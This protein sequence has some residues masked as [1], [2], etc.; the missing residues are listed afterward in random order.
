MLPAGVFTSDFLKEQV[1]FFSNLRQGWGSIANSQQSSAF[2]W[3]LTAAAD[4]RWSADGKTSDTNTL[5]S[6]CCLTPMPHTLA[7]HPCTTPFPLPCALAP[8]HPSQH[9][10][11]RVGLVSVLHP[12]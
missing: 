5:A 8:P 6:N 4:S 2:G 9:F 7:Q 12:R 11:R 3:R 10:C 1:F